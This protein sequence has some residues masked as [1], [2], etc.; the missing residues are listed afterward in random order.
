MAD[1]QSAEDQIVESLKKQGGD[2][3]HMHVKVHAPYKTYFDAQAI[4]L[5]A[6]NDTG[7][8]D[9]LAQHHNFMTILRPCTIHIRTDDGEQKIQVQQGVM[10]VK[11]DE[12][13]V[14]L[15]V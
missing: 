1:K 2:D 8:F 11:K 13:V 12:V 5:T 10:H 3:T 14:F 7:V 4:S 6:E 9:V 15:D